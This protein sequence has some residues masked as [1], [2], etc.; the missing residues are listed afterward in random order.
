MEV[1]FGY[2]D[3]QFANIDSYLDAI[4]KLVQSCD[5]TLGAPVRELEERFT[6]LSGMPYSVGVGSGTDALILSLKI[7]GIGPGDEVVTTPN[8]FIATVG[9][10]AMT[11]ARPAF[12]DSNLDYTIDV[13]QIEAAITPSTKAILPVHYTGRPAEMDTIMDI[14]RKYDLFVVEDACT[15]ILAAINGRQVGTWGDTGCYSM[16]PLKNLN[17]WGDGGVIVTKSEDVY[18]KLKLF[19]NHGLKNR[20]EVL[21]F[22]H[23]SRLD[24]IQAVIANRLMEED[25]VYSITDRRIQNAMTYDK[26]FSDL[27]EFISI[28]ERPNNIKQVFHLYIIRVQDRNNL[29]RFLNESGIKA[30]V[31][32]PIPIHLQKAASYLGYKAGDFPVAEEHSRISISLPCHQYLTDDE[33]NYVIE[34]VHEFYLG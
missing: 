29:L 33:I 24:S 7:L 25:N 30:K 3:R 14:A 10:I 21:M 32:Y 9:A 15:A 16:H 27:G 28:P 23:N 19:R 18:N 31:H 34:K 2:L 1:P 20:D 8:T 12:V 6:E 4:K 5:F 17:I 26:A 13:S 11:G 22:G